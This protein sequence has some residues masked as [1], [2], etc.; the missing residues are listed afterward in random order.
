MSCDWFSDALERAAHLWC[1]LEWCMVHGEW[2]MGNQGGKC[3]LEP[4]TSCQLL[5]REKKKRKTD[6]KSPQKGSCKIGR[7]EG[8]KGRWQSVHPKKPTMVLET[9]LCLCAQKATRSTRGFRVVLNE[10]KKSRPQPECRKK[11][12][13]ARAHRKIFD[14]W[15]LIRRFF[16]H[17]EK[18]WKF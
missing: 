3:D 2:C 7:E 1:I 17:R 6:K 12:T 10:K 8:R 15:F 14:R 16:R 13:G 5:W 18:R 4:N 11:E 9:E